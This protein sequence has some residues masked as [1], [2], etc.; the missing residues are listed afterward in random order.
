MHRKFWPIASVTAVAGWLISQGAAALEP[1]VEVKPLASVKLEIYYDI[2]YAQVRVN[3][4]K[5]VWF[6]IDSGANGQVIDLAYCTKL[7]I[8]TTGQATGQGAGAGTYDVTFANDVTFAVESLKFKVAKCGVIDLSGVPTPENRKLAGLF[9]YDF[10]QSYVVV[11]DY[12]K[13]AMSIYDPKTYQYDGSG[14]SLPLTFKNKVPFVK[15]TIKVPGQATAEREWL[16]DTGSGDLI[17]DELLAQSNGEK[18]KV[19]GG[20]G[21][22][23]KFETWQATAERV[24]LGGLHFE[25]VQGESG[26]MKVGGG[27]LRHFTVIFD[28][29]GNRM[30]LEPNR[31]YQR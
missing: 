16:V 18:K 10:F 19:V 30:I 27:L 26:G 4:S 29:G 1:D 2:P 21:L 12:E 28:Y 9:G 6:I 15:A 20:Y 3:D 23:K 17:N 8:P 24:G 22:G 25:N 13:S 11:I 14:E 5:P 31:R 7:R